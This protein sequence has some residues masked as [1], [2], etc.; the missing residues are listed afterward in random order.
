[1]TVGLAEF[2]RSTET[3]PYVMIES[4]QRLHALQVVVHEGSADR[5]S[6]RPTIVFE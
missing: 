3:L 1:M 2:I 4:V 5:H 6:Y